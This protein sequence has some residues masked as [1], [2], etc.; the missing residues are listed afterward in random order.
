MQIYCLKCKSQ[1]ECSNIEYATSKNNRS[2][3]KGVCNTCG[4]KCSKFL[5][6]QNMRL[7]KHLQRKK[8]PR[9]L[10]TTE[11]TPI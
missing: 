7:P 3:V 5:K 11:T 2:L 9:K 1:K 10:K 4:K 6:S 8:K